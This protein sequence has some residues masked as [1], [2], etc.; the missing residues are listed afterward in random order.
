MVIKA[1]NPRKTQKGDLFM[2]FMG[3]FSS[4]EYYIFYYI[5]LR[6]YLWVKDF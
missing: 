6:K 2:I 3:S 1:F 4:H 5:Y